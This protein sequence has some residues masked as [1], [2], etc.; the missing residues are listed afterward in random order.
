[1]SAF[2]DIGREAWWLSEATGNKLFKDGASL[3]F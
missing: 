3:V 2:M 1:M